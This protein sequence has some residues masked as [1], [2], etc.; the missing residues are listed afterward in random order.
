MDGSAMNW[1]KETAQAKSTVICGSMMMKDQEQFYN[2]L[3]WMRP[4]GSFEFYDKRHLFGLGEEH[5][6]FSA[7]R[8]KILVE[9]KAGKFSHSSA[10]IYV[11]RF[12]AA[13]GP[14]ISSEGEA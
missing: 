8:K 7:G 10:M 2:R 4:D 9:L 11:F 13:T 3:I 5:N 6:H 12:G 14:L 1:M